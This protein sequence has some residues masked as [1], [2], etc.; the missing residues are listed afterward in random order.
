MN[1]SIEIKRNKNQLAI[2][3]VNNV[4]MHSIH[5]PQK[6]AQQI[7]TNFLANLNNR[8]SVLILGLG[9]G[10]HVEQLINYFENEK[11]NFEIVV[12]EPNANLI[13]QFKT[14]RNIS[15]KNTR[16]LCYNTIEDYYNNISLINFLSQKP[17]VLKLETS[18]MANNDFFK[19]FLS[20]K[21]KKNISDFINDIN[22]DLKNYFENSKIDLNSSI[23]KFSSEIKNRAVINDKN[24]FLVLALD[25]LIKT[26]KYVQQ[27]N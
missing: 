23:V 21:G 26:T 11:V 19:T 6:E 16:V 25:E 22:K 14:E 20:Y 10:Y 17:A 8:T 15:L 18:L 13:E 27:G 12:I 4:T 24:D 7:I 1:N 5:D 9:F 3:V 2:P